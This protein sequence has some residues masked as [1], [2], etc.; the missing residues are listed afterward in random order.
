VRTFLIL[1]CVTRV[2]PSIDRAAIGMVNVAKGGARRRRRNAK[3]AYM[4]EYFHQEGGE[5]GGSEE[6]FIG[7][8][9]L[10]I[11]GSGEQT[12]GVEIH[13]IT[14]RD[15]CATIERR[16]LTFLACGLER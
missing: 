7:A 10:D 16:L 4:N 9:R 12:T 13:E 14:K 2:L 1:P 6:K 5:R 8:D 15:K 11:E 3:E